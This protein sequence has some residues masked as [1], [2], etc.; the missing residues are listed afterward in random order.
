MYKVYKTNNPT[1]V[2][3]FQNYEDVQS[4]IKRAKKGK[5]YFTIEEV[6]DLKKLATVAKQKR[7]RDW[8]KEIDFSDAVV[9]NRGNVKHYYKRSGYIKVINERGE[10]LHIGRTTNMGKVFSNYVNCA[11]YMQSYDFDLD[12]VNS[13]DT[14]LFKEAKLS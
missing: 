6:V 3:E 1:S 5:G 11:R 8:K 4:Y 7:A 14:L 12:A 9:I 13:K 2:K 10:T